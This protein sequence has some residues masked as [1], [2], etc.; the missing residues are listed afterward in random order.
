MEVLSE[1][2]TAIVVPLAEIENTEEEQE[3]LSE[4]SWA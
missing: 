2:A 4:G 3:M 1:L